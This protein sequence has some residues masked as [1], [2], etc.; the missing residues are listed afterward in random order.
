MSSNNNNS[1]RARPI[2]HLNRDL[3]SAPDEA[4]P[5]YSYEQESFLAQKED[6]V[7]DA[8]FQKH[9]LNRRDSTGSQG[10]STNNLY[11]EGANIHRGDNGKAAKGGNSSAAA[12]AAAGG[13]FW[14]VEALQSGGGG[15][16]QSPHERSAVMRSPM[17][18]GRT[19]NVGGN[20]LKKVGSGSGGGGSLLGAA[21]NAA[22]SAGSTGSSD[23]H[24]VR[25]FGSHFLACHD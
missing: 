23:T 1:S 21:L 10:S 6:D 14:R 7:E 11:K 3:R 4:E 18:T 2:H 8:Y 13:S 22:S 24:S 9:P 5:S 19:R 16:G 25:S 12:A 17:Q 15:S 20:K